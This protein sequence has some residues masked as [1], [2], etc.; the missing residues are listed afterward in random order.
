MVGGLR[1]QPLD[2]AVWVPFVTLIRTISVRMRAKTWSKFREN[3]RRER[4][5]SEYR[6]VLSFTAATSHMWV[7]KLIK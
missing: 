3:G 2:L 1:I 4:G 6:L 5:V 7:F